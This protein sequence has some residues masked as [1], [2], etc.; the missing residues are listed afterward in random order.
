M[1]YRTGVIADRN[2]TLREKGFSTF[3]APVTLTLTDDL[4]IRT[5]SV[6]RQ[7]VPED[8]TETSY[9]KAFESYGTTDRTAREVTVSFRTR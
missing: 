8:Q 6:S 1:F 4:H 7:D 2:F 5:R 9:V 3:F